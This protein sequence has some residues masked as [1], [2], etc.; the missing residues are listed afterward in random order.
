MSLF[1]HD[2]DQPEIIFY[3]GVFDQKQNVGLWQNTQSL[4]TRG[5]GSGT[6]DI[7]GFSAGDNLF[8]QVRAVGDPMMIGRILLVNLSLFL[9]QS[10]YS[11]HLLG[12]LQV[13][14]PC[15]VE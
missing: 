2:G 7:G 8:Y 5:I 11:W 15:M 4:G 10:W 3:W 6:L 14:Y 1:P 9:L 12:R 13:P